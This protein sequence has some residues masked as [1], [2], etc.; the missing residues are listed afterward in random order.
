MTAQQLATFQ[1]AGCS[2]NGPECAATSESAPP[3]ASESLPTLTF[4]EIHVEAQPGDVMA[5]AGGAAG[6]APDVCDQPPGTPLDR[7]N[8]YGQHDINAAST[9]VRAAWRSAQSR[10]FES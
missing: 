3:P 9:V 7:Y 5:G 2:S 6:P 4:R 8:N 10:E 1:V